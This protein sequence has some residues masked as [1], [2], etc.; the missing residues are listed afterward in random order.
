MRKGTLVRS[1]E[2]AR[3]IAATT[4]AVYHASLHV[5]LG[6]AYPVVITHG[7][8]FVDLFF[9]LSGFVICATYSS[10]LESTS[11]LGQFIMR[12][13]GRLLPLLLFATAAYV[14]AQNLG[15]I[16]K[17]IFHELGHVDLLQN[18]DSGAYMI[19]TFGEVMATVTMTHGLGFFDRNI[20]NW[21]SWSISVE[22]YTYL[23]FAAV[24]I[25]LKGS[26]R[27]V[28]FAVL[29]VVAYVVTCWATASLHGCAGSNNCMDITYDFG[30]T[31]CVASFFLGALMFH[32][33]KRV[34][35]S[36]S[37]LQL[38]ALTA[39]AA[40][41]LSLRA[42]PLSSLFLPIAFA[43]LILSICRDEGY[44]A[45]PL[46]SKLA[47]ELGRRSYSIYLMH[48]VILV[49]FV[50]AMRHVSGLLTGLCCIA[51]YIGCLYVVS[52]LTYRLVEVPFGSLIK[53]LASRPVPRQ[54]SV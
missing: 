52:G 23:L 37:I 33:N 1:F 27:L 7:F 36:A 25:F 41:F 43:M 6:V 12:R 30:F 35:W 38:I 51:I 19:P 5:N 28:A 49:V 17:Q 39:V 31:R 21:A 26:V 14:I 13:I 45:I 47:L 18:P 29:A 53:R 44:L 32:L 34:R 20:L 42:F 8:L 2:G 15:I 54:S 50:T 48:P 10:V 4:V 40:T 11:N 16:A 24:C 9:V 22:F 46:S 3:G